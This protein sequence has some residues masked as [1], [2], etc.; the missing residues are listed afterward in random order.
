M[1]IHECVQGTTLWTTLRSGIPTAS[2]FDCIVTP[3]GKISKSQERYMFTLLAERLMGHPVAEHISLWMQRGTELEAKAVSY[4]ENVRDMDTVPVGF[5]TNDAGTVG[6]SPDRL[7]GD[8][9]LLEIKVPSEHI[10]M[11]YLLKAGSAYD[12]YRVQ[13]QGQLWI[14]EKEWSDVVSWHPDL[15]PAMM[16]VERDEKFIDLLSKEVMEFSAALEECYRS[17]AAQGWVKPKP[18]AEMASAQW[19][20]PSLEELLKTAK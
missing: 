18:K 7:V 3:S 1:K 12:A 16:R 8:R 10:H 11:S 13:V 5:I 6:A 2:A 15:P 19:G 14:S 4:Y 20:L 9:G 17:L